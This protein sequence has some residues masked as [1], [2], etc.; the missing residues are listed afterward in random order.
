MFD[1]NLRIRMLYM[2][3]V[4]CLV[5]DGHCEGLWHMASNEQISMFDMNLIWMLDMNDFVG[6]LYP[7][8]SG[9]PVT[10]QQPRYE[11]LL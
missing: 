4:I 5:Y 7:G 2:V 6:V 10:A 9:L 8:Y 11:R 3:N 1:M